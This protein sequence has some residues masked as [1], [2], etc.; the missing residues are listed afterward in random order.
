MDG[1]ATWQDKSVV[2]A[3]GD[4]GP[5]VHDAASGMLYVPVVD[6]ADTVAADTVGAA[7]HVY[8]STDQGASWGEH[9]TNT[10]PRDSPVEPNGYAS[11]FP[12]VSVDA[13]GN[14][15]LVYSAP[16]RL[17]AAAPDVTLPE[18]ANLFAIYLQASTDHGESWSAPR[19]LS[20]NNKDA[21][22]PWIAAGANGRIAIVWYENVVGNPGEMLPDEWN[23]KLWESLDATNPAGQAVT[24]T[25]TP[26]PNHV[27]SLCTS[28]TGCAAGGDRSL[29]DYFEVAIDNQGQPVVAWAA[30]TLGTGIGL[31][32]QGTDIYFGGATGTP[33]K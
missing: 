25:L 6:L 9:I 31:A 19:L 30:S 26:T 10:L 3:D 33:L 16:L 24:V 2:G 1:G 13:A 12:V 27:G 20:A 22:M 23:V 17:P 11:D 5:V 4:E 15:Y 32:V 29:L 8:T 21:R 18:E 7:V 14:A 28:G